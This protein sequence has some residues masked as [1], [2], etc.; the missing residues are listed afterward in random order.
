MVLTKD[1]MEGARAAY[2]ALREVH[3]MS[4]ED[5]LFLL[6]GK[7]LANLV[8]TTTPDYLFDILNHKEELFA[9]R[10]KVGDVIEDGAGN[11][12]AITWVDKDRVHFDGV[13]IFDTNKRGRT[14]KY[15]T[16]KELGASKTGETVEFGWENN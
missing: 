9:Q 12:Y 14:I 16:L 13:C 8:C 6:E 1:F 11:E 3:D 7:G 4:E 10:M 15:V 2:R 5:R